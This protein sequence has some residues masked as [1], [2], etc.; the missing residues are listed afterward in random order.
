MMGLFER[1]GGMSA[2]PAPTMPPALR[3]AMQ[4]VNMIKAARDPQAMLEQVLRQNPA[5]YQA[6]QYVRDNGGDPKAA[7]E[8]LAAERGIDLQAYMAGR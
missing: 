7:A 6:A 8:K 3:Q 5:M 1:L 4:T 2:M